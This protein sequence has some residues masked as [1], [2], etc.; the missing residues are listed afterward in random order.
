MSELALLFLLLPVAALSGWV[1][2]RRGSERTSG[3]RVSEL[4]TNYFRGLNYL[5]NEQQDKAI[6]VFLKL[7]EINRDTVETHLALGNLFRRRGEY[8]R[9]VRVHEHLLGRGDLSRTDRERAQ[10]ALPQ[11][12][13]RPRQSVP[14]ARRGRSRD[15]RAPEPD[16]AAEPERGREDRRAA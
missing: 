6:E 9:A 7:A 12:F 4:S 16:C 13:L 3:A 8:Q 14:P 11:D 5:L 1:L 2:G 15:P 10:H